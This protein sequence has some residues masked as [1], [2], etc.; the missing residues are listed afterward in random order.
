M[1]NLEIGEGGGVEPIKDDENNSI[2]LSDLDK[3]CSNG[4][5]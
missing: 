3:M 1:I 4:K 5:K 2:E